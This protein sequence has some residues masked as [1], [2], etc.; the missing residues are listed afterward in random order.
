MAHKKNKFWNFI[1]SFMPG[2]GQMY[3]GFLKRGTS[4]MTMFFA[5]IFL[6]NIINIDWFLFG[7]PVIW[8]YAFF[9]SLNTN[10]LSDEEFSKLEDAFLFTDSSTTFKISK[11]KFRIPAAVV[12]IMAGCYILLENVFYMLRSV[13]GFGYDWWVTEVIFDYFPRFVFAAVIILAGL[14]L[15]KGK[16]IQLDNNDEY[17]GMDKDVL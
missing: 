12:L 1:I 13:L 15:I 7:L 2:A 5:E 4:L 17:S 3:Q 9:D 6:A 14:Y 8:F 16:K 10:D 11:S